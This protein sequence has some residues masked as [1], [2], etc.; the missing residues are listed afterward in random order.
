MT[1]RDH[2][3]ETTHEI[4][5]RLFGRDDAMDINP[6]YSNLGRCRCCVYHSSFSALLNAVPYNE[7]QT[8]SVATDM[9]SQKRNN[10]TCRGVRRNNGPMVVGCNRHLRASQRGQREQESCCASAAFATFSD[11]MGIPPWREIRVD[12]VRCEVVSRLDEEESSCGG[13][14][15]MFLPSTNPFYA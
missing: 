7:I 15:S 9:T 3:N 10:F 13:G 8:K 4:F 1:R 5:R 12:P 6:I 11:V 14:L 2:F